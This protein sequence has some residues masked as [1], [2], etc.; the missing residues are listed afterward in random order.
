M[1]DYGIKLVGIRMPNIYLNGEQDIA[2]VHL[3]KTAGTSIGNWMKEN[4]GP[5]DY[6]E[7]W[8]H[9]T[10]QMMIGDKKPYFT[11]ATVRN[12]WDRLVSAYHFAKNIKSPN[13]N[14]S[15]EQAQFWM[16]NINNYKTWPDFDSWVRNLPKFKLLEGWGWNYM[17]LQLDWMDPRVDIEKQ[18]VTE[19]KHYRDYYTDETKKLVE[20]WFQPDIDTWKYSF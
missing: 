14:I 13:P 11:F 10:L 16:N 18:L 4:K 9:P 17:N 3:P 15:S 20:N 5:R 2:F 7:W 12:P 1:K 19:H 6:K 8:D